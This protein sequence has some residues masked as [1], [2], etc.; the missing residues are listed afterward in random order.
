LGAQKVQVENLQNAEKIC[1]RVK[2]FSKESA[3]RGS[4]QS[5]PAEGER[6]AGLVGVWV[7]TLEDEK[8]HSNFFP[9]EKDPKSAAWEDMGKQKAY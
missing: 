9:E 8:D 4:R 5:P 1:A 6:L 7:V 2:G 3:T